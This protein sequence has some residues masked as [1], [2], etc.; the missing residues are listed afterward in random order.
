LSGCSDDR[1]HRRGRRPR[2][3]SGSTRGR[4]TGRAP[5]AR[6]GRRVCT[7]CAGAR[8]H[9]EWANMRRATDLVPL[10]GLRTG[11]VESLETG[12]PRWM[13]LC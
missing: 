8:K 12:T 3:G 5:R 2:A 9:R 7:P 4:S 1:P 11:T 13:T 6:A 10:I